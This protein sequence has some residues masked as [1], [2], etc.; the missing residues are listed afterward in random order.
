M[1]HDFTLILPQPFYQAMYLEHKLRKGDE[2]FKA[3]IERDLSK[4]DEARSPMTEYERA[5]KLWSAQAY[6]FH[7]AGL[8]YLLMM[9]TK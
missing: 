7:E 2:G 1:W 4:L 6:V 8:I 9:T 3:V 5:N